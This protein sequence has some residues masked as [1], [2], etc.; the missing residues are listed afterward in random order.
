VPVPASAAADIAKLNDTINKLTAAVYKLNQR[1]DPSTPVP[2]PPAKPKAKPSKQEIYGRQTWRRPSWR[3][4][5][6]GGD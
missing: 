2:G 4:P 6:R 1:L 3:D 5:P